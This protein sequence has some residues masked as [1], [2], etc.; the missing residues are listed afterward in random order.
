[1]ADGDFRR[2]LRN[3]ALSCGRTRGALDQ[4]F[5]PS[6]AVVVTTHT[7]YVRW[8]DECLASLAAQWIAPEKVIVS[9]NGDDAG[10]AE[11]RKIAER[12]SA[13][14]LETESANVCVKRNEAAKQTKGP[15]LLFLDGDDW[16]SPDFIERGLQELLDPRVGF[17]YP[18]IQ[19]FGARDQY[20]PAPEWDRDR[21]TVENYCASPSLI[22][23]EAFDMVVGWDPAVGGLMDWN[24]WLRLS[25]AG[26]LG[27]PSKGMLFYRRG[28]DSMLQESGRNG[29]HAKSFAAAAR[30]ALFTPLAGRAWALTRYLHFLRTLEWDHGR[31]HLVLYDNSCSDAFAARIKGF[32]AECDYGATTYFKDDARIG[33]ATGDSLS[34]AEVANLDGYGRARTA[35]AVSVATARAYNRMLRL[36]SDSADLVFVVE[37][38]VEP[39]SD[40]LKRLVEAMGRRSFATG[41]YQSRYY[42]GP[43]VSPN[44]RPEDGRDVVVIER[45]GF[46]CLLVRRGALRNFVFRP[47]VGDTIRGT[48]PVMCRD[49][50]ALGHTGVCDWGVQ[51]NHWQADGTC[52]E[53]KP[54]EDGK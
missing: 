46:G 37:D 13:A 27:A 20:V 26:W 51:C 44:K 32:L 7:P 25:D 24:L 15:I 31:I 3:M 11:A 6:V 19:N 5:D 35:E 45:C 41:V 48:D 10:A 40:A 28:H 23:R 29:W 30:V 21:L 14:F 38:D 2:E 47:K 53:Y 49:L 17:A 33:D 52:L 9:F 34:N 18:S 50:K 22:R 8:L 39:P 4:H 54:E 12:H 42:R 16:L 43:V 36:V 1:M